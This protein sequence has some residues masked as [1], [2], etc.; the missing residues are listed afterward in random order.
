MAKHPDQLSSHA[1]RC[2]ECG[3]V[4]RFAGSVCSACIRR[5]W[6]Q[7]NATCEEA[8]LVLERTT[9]ARLARREAATRRQQTGWSTLR[10][11]ED[12]SLGVGRTQPRDTSVVPRLDYRLPQ[13]YSTGSATASQRANSV[14]C[15]LFAWGYGHPVTALL[16]GTF[17]ATDLAHAFAAERGWDPARSGAWAAELTST[18][19]LFQVLELLGQLFRSDPAVV[20]WGGRT[21]CAMPS[22]SGAAAPSGYHRLHQVMQSLQQQ[23]AEIAARLEAS[24]QLRQRLL[25]FRLDLEAA[26]A[27]RAVEPSLPDSGPS[28]EWTLQTPDPAADPTELPTSEFRV[29]NQIFSRALDLAQEGRF[30]EGYTVLIAGLRRAEEASD[31]EF[32]WA[33]HLI[34]VY[35]E[36]LA[37]YARTFGMDLPS[38]DE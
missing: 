8:R 17:V 37:Y 34:Y 2:S 4:V 30:A 16:Q 24:R 27:A 26:A 18:G 29:L 3:Q 19:S 13:F 10:L 36:S 22:P 38:M 9:R 6:D 14:Q 25:Q 28:I 35:N 5:R 21:G 12:R 32:S 33:D 15:Q 31:H 7:A 23:R 11:E 20:G 1:T